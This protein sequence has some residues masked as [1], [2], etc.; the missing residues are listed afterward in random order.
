[1]DAE[2]RLTQHEIIV[3]TVNSTAGTAAS[4]QV[5]SSGYLG[6]SFAA[7]AAVG[8]VGALV[9]AAIEAHHKSVAE[10]A[11][12]PIRDHTAGLDLDA[13]I[14]QSTDSLDRHLFADEITVQRMPVTED[15]DTQQRALKQGS[16]ILV[17]SP[18][19]WVSYDGSTFTYTLNA[20]IVD[21]AT[22]MNGFVVSTPRYQQT[23]QYAADGTQWA[24]LTQEQWK[25]LLDEAARETV[26]M[27]NYDVTISPRHDGAKVRYGN[28]QVSID[29]T[30]GERSWVRTPFGVLLS[31]SSTALSPKGHS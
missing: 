18:S 15:A 31:V 14:V 13:L 3:A 7:G 17:L 4:M 2:V 24:A 25:S 19:Y 9:D 27:L 12:K 6:G 30:K 21:R 16:N 28:M 22:N 23:F 5:A 11:V 1:M 26:A 8:I 20:R 29:Q 10:E